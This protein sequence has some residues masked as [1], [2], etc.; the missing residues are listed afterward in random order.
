MTIKEVENELGIARANIRF[1]EK[2]KLLFPKR[3]PLN[4]YREYTGEDIEILR[5]IIYLRKLDISIESISA[6]QQGKI[7]LQHVLKDQ[8]KSL[9]S[10]QEKTNEAILLCEKLIVNP[11]LCFNNFLMEGTT[12]E[13][14]VCFN[15]ELSFWLYL[16]RD[17]IL[18]ICLHAI[19]VIFSMYL[20]GYL[21]EEIPVLWNGIKPIDFENKGIIFC[22]FILPLIITIKTK[23]DV[24]MF[25]PLVFRKNLYEI[26]LMFFSGIIMI[27]TCL[28]I[29]TFL[30]VQ[31]CGYNFYLY[32][33]LCV[34]VMLIGMIVFFRFSSRNMKNSIHI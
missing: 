8:I 23:A 1:Y 31:G 26:N 34:V 9:K 13:N 2:E 14:L 16:Y 3:N 30:S 27:P 10:Q 7:S 25:L 29:F 17:K 20:L 33:V 19:Q 6:I 15:S 24:Y 22:Y 21:P 5:R 12:D 4:G 18:I 28:Q 11:D 32:I